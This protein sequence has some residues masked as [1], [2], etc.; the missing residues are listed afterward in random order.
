MRHA[1]VRS[2]AAAAVLGLGIANVAIAAPTA[3][4]TASPNPALP[5][6]TINFDGSASFD[7]TGAV[8]GPYW[9]DWESDGVFDFEGVFGTHSFAALGIYSVTLEVTNDAGL[10]DTATVR[11]VVQDNTSGIPEPTTLA[12]LGL[13][14]AGLAATRRRKQ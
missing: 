8:L 7:P 9:W 2:L 14:L 4:A 11:I 3:V 1:R 12:L 6:Q 13:G 5:G 10:S